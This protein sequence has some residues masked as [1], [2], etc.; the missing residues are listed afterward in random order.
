ML[1]FLR[2]FVLCSLWVCSMLTS[3]ICKAQ[4]LSYGVKVGTNWGSVV[5]PV[6]E[7][8][9]GRLKFYPN[10]GVFARWQFAPKWYL[11]PELNYSMKGADYSLPMQKDSMTVTIPTLEFPIRAP[12]TSL[13]LNCFMKMHYLELPLQVCYRY[14]KR[15]RNEINAGIQLGYMLHGES[16][17]KQD[18]IIVGDYFLVYTDSI[19]NLAPEFRR[20]DYAATLGGNIWLDKHFFISTRATCSIRSIYRKEL[21][22][23]EAN[24]L[25]FFIFAG[26]GY[27]FK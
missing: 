27:T 17:I 8:G 4:N 15:Q 2:L 12:Y 7:G 19:T 24:F 18:S 11:Q 6:E 3:Q 25:N 22:Q 21:E 20:M 14:G 1:L 16:E 26:L 10:A 13:G 23:L 9:K 5:G